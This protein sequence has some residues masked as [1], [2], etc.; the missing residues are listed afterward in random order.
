MR[1]FLKLLSI[2]AFAV[3]VALIA[4]EVYVE[5]LPNPARD[6]HQWMLKH[7]RSVE[8]LILGSSHTYYNVNPSLVPGKAFNLALPSQTYRYDDYLL[9][10]YP[11]DSLRTLILPYSY[12]SMYEDFE[13]TPGTEFDAIRYRIYMDCD[14][15][16][17][18][19]YYGFEF[20]AREPFIEKL[21]SL[22]KDPKLKWNELGWGTSYSYDQREE[23]WD[24]GEISAKNNTH[25]DSLLVPLNRR[26]LED[27]M[28][29]CEE[30][31]VRLILVTT[32]VSPIFLANQSAL[33]D[34]VNKKVLRQLLEKHPEVVYLDYTYDKDF[35]DRDFH[36]SHHLD[37]YGAEKLT[38]KLV[39]D[40]GIFGRHPGN[41][42]GNA[43][44]N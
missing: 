24:D 31:N 19:S 30:R 18:I 21:K 23:D 25:T 37:E 1:G 44:V 16:P 26:F 15:H 11:L 35:E 39:R 10:H 38:V 12:F 33:Q 6:K 40:S 43:R 32:P 9:H 22:Y 36:D 8:T 5:N 42:Q 2:F 14:I 41:K 28:T 20:L 34:E 29:Y 27:I 7:S 13:E 3:G 4:A 17:R